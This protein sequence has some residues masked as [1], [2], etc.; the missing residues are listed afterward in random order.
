M[1]GKSTNFQI[2]YDEDHNFFDDELCCLLLSTLLKQLGEKLD[3]VRCKAG[4]CLERLLTNSSP[5]LLFVPHR[6]RLVRALSLRE[7]STNWADPAITFPLV[8]RVVNID[9]FTE[10]ILSGIVIS[11]GGLTESVSKSSSAALFEWIRELRSVTST[12]KIFRM[13]EG[14]INIGVLVVIYEFYLSSFFFFKYFS[15]CSRSTSGMRG[16]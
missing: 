9:E 7:Q 3:V 13:G 14:A 2:V 12:Q 15:G 11:V 16:F 8:M 4:E 10:P 1:A 5:R 6:E